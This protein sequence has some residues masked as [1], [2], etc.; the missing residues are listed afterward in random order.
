MPFIKR[1]SDPRYPEVDD[2]EN[3]FD[4]PDLDDDQF[5]WRY[6]SVEQYLSLLLNS[7]LYFSRTDRFTD[8][9]EGTL[10]NASDLDPDVKPLYRKFR[11]LVHM[12]CWHVNKTESILMWDSYAPSG[13]VIKTSLPRLIDALDAEE[14][15]SIHIC[16]VDYLNFSHTDIQLLDR[17]EDSRS[18]NLFDLFQ[19]KR[20]YYSEEREIRLITNT[21]ADYTLRGELEGESLSVDEWEEYVEDEIRIKVDLNQ[22]LEEVIIHPSSDKENI[23]A[24]KTV[25]NRIHN[26]GDRIIRSEI[27]GKPSF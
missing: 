20:E 16:E 18:G 5:L 22:L 14:D 24:L 27:E 7:S 2:Y 9:F 19:Y 13:V 3:A 23:K 11:R 15:Y 17:D 8:E 26:L 12:N 1:F 4:F 21:M 6:L 10:P 25:T